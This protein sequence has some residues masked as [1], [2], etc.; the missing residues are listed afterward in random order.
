MLVSMKYRILFTFIALFTVN[1]CLDNNLVWG[2]EAERQA[3][4]LARRIVPSYASRIDFMQTDDTT[5]VFTICSRGSKLVIEGNNAI[6]MATGLNYYL[7]NYCGVTVSWYAFDPVQYPAQMPAVETPVRVE[8]KVKDRFFLNYCTFG[9]T[10][11]WWK[12]EDWERL[13]DWMALNGINMPL[14][15]TGQEAVWQ[16]VWRKHGLSDEEI[17]SYFT[18]PAHLPWHRMCNIDHYDGPLPQT[19][20]DSQAKLQKQILKR[21]RALGMRPVLQAFGGHV[22]EQLK[23]IY[24]QAQITDVPFWGTFPAENLCHFLAPMDPLY[25]QIQ[26][27]YMSE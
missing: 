1:L 10:M 25:S 8:A 22:P 26:R 21:E 24:P 7:K 12:W 9:Y 2:T 16:K 13:I 18:G 19:W 3:K 27:E 23:E 14:A 15:N 4:D 11:P 5:D 6:S 17:R 20:I